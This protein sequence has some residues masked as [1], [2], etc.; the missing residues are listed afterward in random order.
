[1]GNLT[2]EEMNCRVWT[3]ELGAICVN[4]EYRLAPEHPFPTAITDS[5]DALPWAISHAKSFNADPS[6]GLIVEGA[7]ACGNIAAV[8]AHMARDEKLEP[9]VTG[10]YLCAPAV[11]NLTGVPEKYRDEYRS[12]KEAESD[13]VL[14]KDGI[15]TILAAY[16][17]D[18]TS[19]LWYP[20]NHP[21]GHSGL[22]KAYIQ[23]GG[24][25]PL[26]DEML[27]YERELLACG[28]ETRLDL[29]AG[30]GHM[31]HANYP[32]MRRGLEFWGDMLAGMRWLL[33]E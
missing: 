16:Q 4:V 27:L 30:Y 8:L 3:R 20:F 15:D 21:A 17:P 6:L 28:M 13:P 5:W 32:T 7:S 29:Y 31:F 10:Q 26:R 2:N 22:A 1:M 12:R 25:D 11:L 18:P 14:K 9:P 23:I 24:I 33:E 19:W